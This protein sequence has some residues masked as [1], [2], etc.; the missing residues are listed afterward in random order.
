[1]VNGLNFFLKVICTINIQRSRDVRLP[2]Y[3]KL[4][5]VF[6]LAHIET[7]KDL[8]RVNSLLVTVLCNLHRNNIEKVNV[9]VRA[10]VKKKEVGWI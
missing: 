10:L 9:Y 2:T 5:E 4:R 7:Y 3:N 1:M 6:S 8:A